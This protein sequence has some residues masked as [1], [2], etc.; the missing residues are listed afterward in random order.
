M[1]FMTNEI[2]YYFIYHLY[3]ICFKYVKSMG[4]VYEQDII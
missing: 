1:R 4:K 3:I 2:K